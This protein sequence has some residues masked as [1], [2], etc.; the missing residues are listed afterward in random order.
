[1]AVTDRRPA[2]SP[3]LTVIVIERPGENDDED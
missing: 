3:M 1:M 2:I